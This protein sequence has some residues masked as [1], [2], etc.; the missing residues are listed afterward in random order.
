MVGTNSPKR[1]LKKTPGTEK[2]KDILKRAMASLRFHGD[3][4]FII[5]SQ[6]HGI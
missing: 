4:D 3:S 1:F 6:V 5:T 2:L